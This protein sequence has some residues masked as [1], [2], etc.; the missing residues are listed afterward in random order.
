MVQDEV[1]AGST[2][3]ISTIILPLLHPQDQRRLNRRRDDQEREHDCEVPPKGM[4][5]L[6]SNR[7]A[8]LSADSSE[9]IDPKP[10]AVVSRN[11]ERRDLQDSVGQ[12]FQRR[13]RITHHLGCLTVHDTQE[14]PVGPDGECR[15]DP[16]DDAGDEQKYS[17]H[18][19]VEEDREKEFPTFKAP[20]IVGNNSER[21]DHLLSGR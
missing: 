11:D 16:Y 15:D 19:I 10:Q 1:T 2:S 18:N 21:F 13:L 5:H 6:A 12:H 4:L 14:K 3:L 8:L 9:D 17:R 20:I 7:I